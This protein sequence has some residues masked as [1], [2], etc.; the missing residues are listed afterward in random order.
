[1]ADFKDYFSTVAAEYARF[2]PTYPPELFA[3]LASLPP[4]RGLALDCGTGSGQAAVGLARYFDRVVATDP[5]AEQLRHAQAHDRVE[6][7]QA[8]AEDSGLPAGTVDLV[9]VAAALHWFDLDRF[10]AETRRV[11]RPGGFLV[12][13]AY[14]NAV[15]APELDACLHDYYYD[16]VGPYWPPERLLVEHRYADVPFPFEEVDPPVL[17]IRAEWVLSD[18]VNYLMTWSSTRLA[19]QQTGRNPIE[20]VYGELRRAWGPPDRPRTVV[21]PLGIR[22]GRVPPVC[23]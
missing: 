12:A 5:S 13:W 16:V 10:Y 1:M 7:R 8:P 17:E 9:A 21:W 6:Y 3:W 20:A 4:S 2:R 11:L 18:L 22:A 15:I 23:P 19:L 14:T